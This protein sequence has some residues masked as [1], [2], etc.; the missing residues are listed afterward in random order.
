MIHAAYCKCRWHVTGGQ[1]PPW[2]MCIDVA[3][4]WWWQAEAPK[5]FKFAGL[6]SFVEFCKRDLRTLRLVSHGWHASV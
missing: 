2:L 4:W 5:F 6:W 1:W 3:T